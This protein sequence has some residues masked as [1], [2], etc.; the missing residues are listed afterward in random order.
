[1]IKL[2]K[3]KQRLLSRPKDFTFEELEGLL[4]K[5]GYKEIKP[6]K[7]A[8]SRKVFH[9]SE[10]QHIIRLHKPHPKNILK[11]YVIHMVIEEL[12]KVNGL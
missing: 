7:T 3:L 12:R 6:G 2:D 10:S 11:A 1:M 8:G 4:T 9:H 5:L